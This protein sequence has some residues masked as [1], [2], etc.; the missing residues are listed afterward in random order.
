M[1]WS[2]I[3]PIIWPVLREALIAALVAI[4]ALLGYDQAVP[5]R[6]MRAGLKSKRIKEG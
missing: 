5:S 3:W 4:L 1:D 2:E 6:Y